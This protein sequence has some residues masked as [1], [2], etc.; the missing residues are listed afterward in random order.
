MII[1]KI[2]SANSKHVHIGPKY[3][4]YG[5]ILVQ[6]APEKGWDQKIKTNQFLKIFSIL[7]IQQ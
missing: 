4:Q 1:T 7:K 6:S 3:V 5:H 2:V